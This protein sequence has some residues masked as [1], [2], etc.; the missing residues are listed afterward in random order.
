MFEACFDELWQ[1]L[2]H[3]L[4]FSGSHGVEHVKRV[5]ELCLFIGKATGADLEILLPAAILHDAGRSD[6]TKGHSWESVRI[7]EE[8]LSKAGLDKLKIQMIGEAIRSHSYEAEESPRTLEAKILSDADKLDALG[9]VGIFRAAAYAA[10]EHR[11][12]EDF[13]DHFH[14]KLLKLPELMYTELAQQMALRRRAFMYD[15]LNELQHELR[16][17]A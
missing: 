9:S 17:E 14:E 1:S 4:P 10:E 3:Y 6:S 2:R 16:L 13:M 5:Y 11:G 12:T 8:L 7:S 15:Y